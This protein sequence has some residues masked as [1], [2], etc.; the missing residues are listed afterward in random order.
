MDSDGGH[1]TVPPAHTA[2]LTAPSSGLITAIRTNP[3]SE[4]GAAAHAVVLVDRTIGSSVV[5]GTPIAAAWP[6]DPRRALTDEDLDR[7]QDAVSQAVLIGFER[8][9]VGA[10]AFGLRQLTDVA[11]KALSPRI[12]DPTT[13]THALGHGAALLCRL[14]HLPLGDELVRGDTDDLRVV[15]RRP[16]LG[17]L[18][19]LAVNQPLR[20]G[21]RE[22]PG[23]RT[24]VPPAQRSRAP[25]AAR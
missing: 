1:L 9:S 18:L 17:D 8:T 16:T 22:P 7:L 3:L 15:V 19:E 2:P 14:A 5:R 12:N 25:R 21:S 23:R 10:G 11:V 13:A 6:A 24:A 20:Y 4:A